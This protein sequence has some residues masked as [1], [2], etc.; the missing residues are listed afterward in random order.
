MEESQ[1]RDKERSGVEL[2]ESAGDGREH[3]HQSYTGVNTRGQAGVFTTCLSGS[4]VVLWVGPDC[5]EP[6]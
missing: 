1:R 5:S 2:E 3:T 4:V 6:C